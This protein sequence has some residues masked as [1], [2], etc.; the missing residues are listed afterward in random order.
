MLSYCFTDVVIQTARP[1]DVKHRSEVQYDS[2]HIC[3]ICDVQPVLTRKTAAY[4]DYA[5]AYYDPILTYKF[6]VRLQPPEA[7]EVR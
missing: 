6:F 5:A 4:I 3:S 2:L 7:E 1:S